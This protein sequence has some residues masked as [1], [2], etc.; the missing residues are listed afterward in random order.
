MNSKKTRKRNT[1]LVKNIPDYLQSSNKQTA[2]KTP[3]ENYSSSKKI[4]LVQNENISRFLF[5]N[6]TPKEKISG[7]I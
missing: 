3:S 2:S 5:M 1:P 7:K 4:N 6:P